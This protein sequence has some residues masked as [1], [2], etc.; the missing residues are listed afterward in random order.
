MLVLRWKLLSRLFL[1]PYSPDP[2]DQTFRAR[3]QSQTENGVEVT[4]AVP[5]SRESERLFGVPMSR[6]GLQPIYLRVVNRSDSSLRLHFRSIDPHYFPPLEA[7]ARCHYSFLKRLSA[8]GLFGLFFYWLLV[9][10][11]LKLLSVRWANRQMDAW[12]QSLGFHRRPIAPGE[13][14]EGFVFAAFDAGTK[15]VRVQL[16]QVDFSLTPATPLDDPTDSEMAEFRNR[17]TI[18]APTFGSFVDLT[19]AVAVAGINADHLHRKL[20]SLVPDD[21]AQNC[22]LP[23]LVARLSEISPV[24][25]NRHGKGM[26]DPVNL[27]V[28][29]DFEMLLNAFAGRWDETEVISLLTCW[30]TFKA[31]LLGSEYRYSPV[32][33]LYLFGRSQDVA[34]QQIRRSISQRLHLRL[35]ISEMT[36]GKK[37]VWVG[38]VSRD[39]GVRLTATTWNLTTHRI[40]SDIDES[41]DY[42]LEDLLDAERVEAAG[43]VNVPR[44][45]HATSPQ[46]NLTGDPYYTDGKRV[47]I[48]LGSGRSAPRF[49]AW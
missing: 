6:R 22:D 47:V 34:L 38:Q 18:D 44:T 29:G 45:D 36:F 13:Q 9:L 25:R 3:A 33:S 24:T 12:F 48:L 39:I 8:F 27:V 28:I 30:K 5:D 4:V 15:V 20:D 14:S 40:D 31:F 26:G 46:Y 17:E 11:P 2:D 16:L 1:I 35:W 37:P 42:V 43:Y 21:D 19:F 49:V 10:A 23:T 32:S 7:A 41:R